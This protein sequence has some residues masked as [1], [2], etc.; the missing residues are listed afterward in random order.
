MNKRYEYRHVDS[1]SS[2]LLLPAWF[3]INDFFFYEVYEVGM[4]VVS[5]VDIVA[6][7]DLTV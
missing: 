5:S 1:I 7:P 6:F 3:L 4:P 2:S